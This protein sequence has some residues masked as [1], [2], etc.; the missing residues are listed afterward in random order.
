MPKNAT[1]K[2]R[3]PY[4]FKPLTYELK[5][6]VNSDKKAF[7]GELIIEGQKM[8]PPNKRITLN[9][10][11][12]KVIKAQIIYHHKN[13]DIYLE[14][15]RINHLKSFEEVRLHVN[16]IMYPGAYT[17]TLQY[18]GKLI[19]KDLELLKNP[20]ANWREILPCVEF[21]DAKQTAKIKAFFG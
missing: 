7:L 19:P 16:T 2:A 20:S 5:L 10:K 3:L 6:V 11:G 13:G 14:V 8:P 4:N 12:L 21:P 9:Q 17:L 1:K 15:A 18:C